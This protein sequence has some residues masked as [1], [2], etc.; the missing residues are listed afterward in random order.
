MATRASAA[1][2]ETGAATAATGKLLP[3]PLLVAL[4][5]LD[6][7]GAAGGGT[8]GQFEPLSVGFVL[9]RKQS[10]RWLRGT[11]ARACCGR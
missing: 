11:E 4:A 6:A 9:R 3:P 2:A 5:P 10:W 1:T 8:A 7:G